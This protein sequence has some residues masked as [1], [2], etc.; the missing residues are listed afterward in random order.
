MPDV[1]TIVIAASALIVAVSILSWIVNKRRERADARRR[2][3][4]LRA[5]RERDH[6]EYAE[7]ERLSRRIIAT[8][9]TATIAG[10]DIERQIEAVVTDGHPT[11]PAAV[12]ALKAHA[13][14]LGANAVINLDSQRLGT[15]KC[16]ARGDAVIVRPRTDAVPP[17]AESATDPAAPGS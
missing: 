11:P 8:S 2:G 6:I 15:G 17:A 12:E 14:R 16:S 5:Q 1:V 4:W 3:E 13:A 7:I 10:F 9:S